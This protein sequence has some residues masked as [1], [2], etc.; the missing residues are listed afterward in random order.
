M[1]SFLEANTS[2]EMPH[3][4]WDWPRGLDISR[5]HGT[6]DHGSIS[7]KIS[8]YKVCANDLEH[9]APYL[10]PYLIR[11]DM[12]DNTRS[13]AVWRF[14]LSQYRDEVRT[15]S[16]AHIWLSIA[17]LLEVSTLSNSFVSTPGAVCLESA[18]H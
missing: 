7:C 14:A 10:L 12:I 13:L 18:S 5:G 8:P 1:E 3:K 4:D 2:P 15:P 11:Y 16:Q 17:R 6:P 9:G